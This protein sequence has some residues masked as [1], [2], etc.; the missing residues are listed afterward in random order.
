MVK[1]FVIS[2]VV[3]FT[4][5]AIKYWIEN[6]E[7]NI[8]SPQVTAFK[9]LKKKGYIPQTIIENGNIVFVVG[10]LTFVYLNNKE[11]KK[12]FSLALPNIESVGDDTRLFWL[13]LAN[14]NSEIIT[15]VKTLVNQESVHVRYD[16]ILTEK[17]EIKDI[18]PRAI[19][20]L[21]YAREN[22]YSMVQNINEEKI[23]AK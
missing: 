5:S 3:Y 15:C 12:L 1:T 6:R 4:Y 19:D 16:R 20:A 18:L 22:L 10:D 17:D 23:N 11:N 21:I 7:Y 8:A 14:I 13:E 9:Y 2:S